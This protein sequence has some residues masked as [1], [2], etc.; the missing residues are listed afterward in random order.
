MRG[1]SATSNLERVSKLLKQLGQGLFFP[2]NV[3]GWE[4]GRS[5][6]NSS[7]LI[8]RANFV[9]DL[10]AD[11]NTRFDG[12]PLDAWCTAHSISNN[13]W[14][15]WL[16]R[17]LLVLPLTDE[18]KNRCRSGSPATMLGLLARNPKIHLS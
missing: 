11:G 9:V 6:I 12:K 3:K 18:E 17:S 15:E 1:L 8:G 16:E 2:P 10:L 13:E 7:T 4:G 5:W 14:L